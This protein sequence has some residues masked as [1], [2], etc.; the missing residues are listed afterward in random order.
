MKVD[1]IREKVHLFLFLLLSS[2]KITTIFFCKS[3][4]F[5]TKVLSLRLIKHI[6]P[7][8]QPHCGVQIAWTLGFLPI[9]QRTRSL[10]LWKTQHTMPLRTP[11]RA[12]K[13]DRPAMG[14]GLFHETS[15]RSVADIRYLFAPLPNRADFYNKNPSLDRV[16][17]GKRYTG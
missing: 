16:E 5:E 4:W 14:G 8:S 6:F 11:L 12:N 13:I 1:D 2:R 3:R 9:D 10:T 15:A 17:R 7:F